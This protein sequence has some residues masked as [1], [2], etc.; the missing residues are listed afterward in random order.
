[1]FKYGLIVAGGQGKRLRPLTSAIPKPLL[2]LR[3][4]PIILTILENMK[5]QGVEEVFISVNYK[6]EMI[7]N[8]LRDGSRIGIKIHYLEETSATGTAGC[9]AILDP[10]FNEPVLLSNGDLVSD[11]NY[12][13]IFKKLEAFDL[14]ITGI[15]KRVPID[16]GVLS[17]KDDTE[18]TAW[19]EKPDLE[20][21]ISGGVYG[22][23]ARLLNFIRNNFRPGEYLDMPTLYETS[24]KEGLRTGT[25]IHHGEWC[26]VGKVEDYLELA[27]A[28]ELKN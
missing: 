5:S 8:Y 14:V 10:G 2:P 6:K 11:I 27:R 4:K 28:M 22:V 26:D 13:E 17:L 20:Y 18:L 24:R 7:K 3:D 21:V 16:F 23:S 15:C 12:G 1:M 9:L 25:H 19:E